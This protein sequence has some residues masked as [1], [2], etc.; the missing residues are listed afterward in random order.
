MQNIQQLLNKLSKEGCDANTLKEV[1]AL[2]AASTADA[3]IIKTTKGAL[4]VR[5]GSARWPIAMYKNDWKILLSK[6]PLIEEA[7]EKLDI[8]DENPQKEGGSQ[9]F[10]ATGSRGTHSVQVARGQ[11]VRDEEEEA[12]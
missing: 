11:R 3:G 10:R 4:M 9:A 6:V 8:P 1:E 2:A 12:A 7:L 5:V